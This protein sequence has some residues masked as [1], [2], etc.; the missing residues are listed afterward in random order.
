MDNIKELLGQIKL[1]CQMDVAVCEKLEQIDKCIYAL[2]EDSKRQTATM[3]ALEQRYSEIVLII[4]SL[5][6][7]SPGV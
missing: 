4:K 7:S 2:Q 3:R 6:R 5:K 1:F